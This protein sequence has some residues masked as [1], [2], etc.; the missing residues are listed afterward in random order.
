ME[1]LCSID[2]LAAHAPMSSRLFAGTT[3]V[4]VAAA[5]EVICPA[6]GFAQNAVNPCP[7]KYSCF[8][9]FGFG[10]YRP[11]SVPSKGR[12]AIAVNVVRNAVDGPMS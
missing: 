6:G 9:K 8:P 10:V 5:S 3:A 11:R 7:Q 2:P 4:R 1:T 12:I